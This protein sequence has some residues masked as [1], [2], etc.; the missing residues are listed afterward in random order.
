MALLGL[1]EGLSWASNGLEDDTATGGPGVPSAPTPVTAT[2]LT[3]IQILVA[4]GFTASSTSFDVHRA[5][6]IGGPFAIPTGGADV[7]ALTFTDTTVVAATAYFYKIKAKNGDGSS[8]FSAVATDAT[9]VAADTR[10]ILLRKNILRLVKTIIKGNTPGNQYIFHNTIREVKENAKSIE[11]FKRL[12]G[13]NFTAGPVSNRNVGRG[14]AGSGNQF[15]LENSFRGVFDIF[16]KVADDRGSKPVDE[17]D[18]T[19]A[20]LQALFG[21]KYFVPDEQNNHTA[22]NC[23]FAASND[24]GI[25]TNTANANVGVSVE[26]DFWYRISG[27]NPN[28]LV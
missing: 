19:V 28:I 5:T 26:F 13:I 17:A 9:P 15:S 18:Q 14:S 16:L 7:T 24:F 12:P 3:T 20:D 1:S 22:F 10:K 23:L 6:A 4:W 21:N 11:Q 27:T 25:K 8:V 2:A